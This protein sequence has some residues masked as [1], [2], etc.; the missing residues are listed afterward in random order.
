MGGWLGGLFDK[1]TAWDELWSAHCEGLFCSLGH[2]LP[3]VPLTPLSVSPFTSFGS[4]VTAEGIK[5][6]HKHL[7]SYALAF[8]YKVSSFTAFGSLH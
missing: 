4:K 6:L 3:C 2:S 8:F 1:K 5:E 7:L